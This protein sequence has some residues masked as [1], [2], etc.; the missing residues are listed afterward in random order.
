M[1][2]FYFP[3]CKGFDFIPDVISF[4]TGVVPPGSLRNLITF[5][6]I[7]CKKIIGC[8]Y[9]T[10]V[11]SPSIAN[12]LQ[13][14]ERLEIKHKA[15]L[16]LSLPTKKAVIWRRGTFPML[17]RLLFTKLPRLICFFEGEPAKTLDW[18]S[19]EYIHL[20][21]CSNLAR[22]SIGCESTQVEEVHVVKLDDM[23]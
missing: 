21:D 9:S 16:R 22:L 7:N 4:C 5:E 23:D 20:S 2:P 18:P 6:V 1:I 3:N 10:H 8:P 12:E 17:K 11:F 13:S 19:L 15:P 14:L